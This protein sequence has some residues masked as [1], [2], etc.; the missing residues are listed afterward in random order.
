MQQKDTYED[1]LRDGRI[2]ALEGG[3]AG[4]RQEMHDGFARMGTVF[5]EGLSGLGNSIREEF[6]PVCET[7]RGNGDPKK[8][9]ISRL[10]VVEEALA[11]HRWL[12]SCMIAA[13]VAGAVKII[14]F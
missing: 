1:G 10:A 4:L 2:E 14:W 9:I 5:D 3:L 7:V 12:L 11:I 6:R 8:G 13:I